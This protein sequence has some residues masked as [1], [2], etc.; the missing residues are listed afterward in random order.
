MSYRASKRDESKGA[1]NTGLRLAQK[2]RLALHPVLKMRDRGPE[3]APTRR[4]LSPFLGAYMDS[5]TTPSQTFLRAATERYS[6]LLR[7]CADIL[8]RLPFWLEQ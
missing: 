1:M 7:N 4:G 5:T 2:K 8:P 6:H 3:A